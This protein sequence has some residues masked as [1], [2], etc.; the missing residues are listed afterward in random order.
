MVNLQKEQ[1][2][3][4]FQFFNDAVKKTILEN[5][6]KDACKNIDLQV[7]SNSK[8]EKAEN[9]IKDHAL[10]KLEYLMGQQQ[11]ILIVIL[12]EKL[13]FYLADILMCGKGDKPYG[14]V[15]TEVE[16]NSTKKL[17]EQIFKSLEEAFKIK[18]GKDLVFGEKAS[19]I[20]K[21]DAEYKTAFEHLGLNFGVNNKITVNETNEFDFDLLLNY[22][23]VENLINFLSITNSEL[24]IKKTVINP[25]D[26]ERLSDVKINIT[27]ELGKTQIPIKYAL[28]LVRGSI[29]ELDTLNNSDIRVFVNG[30]E[31]AKAQI[32]AVEDYYGLK[33]TEI[34]SPEE[35]IKNL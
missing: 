11:G 23:T 25:A 33:I 27:A 18:Y 34:I 10:Y 21:E 13:L 32:F 3:D 20:L 12:P 22:E 8:I 14:G 1:L 9:L 4:F 16:T 35:R 2:S 7:I 19:L 30:T 28:E 6:D 24:D 29:V 31:F 17:L 5:L 15:L 26:L